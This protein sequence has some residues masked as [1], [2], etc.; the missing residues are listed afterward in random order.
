LPRLLEFQR[1]GETIP[2]LDNRPVIKEHLKIV[3][4]AFYEIFNRDGKV[5]IQGIK[6]WLDLYQV[7]DLDE[8]LWFFKLLSAMDNKRLMLIEENAKN[9]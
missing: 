3:E 1:R 6:N 4:R 9:G 2:D 7:F 8:R 5:S